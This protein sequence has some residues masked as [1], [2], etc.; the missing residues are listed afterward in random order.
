MNSAGHLRQHRLQRV[1]QHFQPRQFGTAQFRHHRGLLRLLDPCPAHS[2]LQA[3]RRH[4]QFPTPF[5]AL[6]LRVLFLILFLAQLLRAN[7]TIVVTH[8]AVQTLT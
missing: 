7:A 8:H 4:P 5:L 6:L 1:T 3:R 2:R